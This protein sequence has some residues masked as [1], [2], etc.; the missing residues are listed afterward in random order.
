MEEIVIQIKDK[1]KVRLLT[2]L[3]QALDFVASVR[4][5]P[6]KSGKRTNRRQKA[7]GDFF[8]FAGIWA[9]REMTITT[10][11]NKAWP[12]QHDSL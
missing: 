1:D 7:E 5:A 6:P 12:R 9:D 4:V 10:L 2:D 8:A 3:L 11:R